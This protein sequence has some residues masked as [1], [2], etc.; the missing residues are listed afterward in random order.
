MSAVVDALRRNDPAAPWINIILR[1]ETSDA[2]LAQ[3]LEQNQ[4]VEQIDLDLR[5]VQTTNWEALL[6]VIATREKL[7]KVILFDSFDADNRNPAA[8][9]SAILRA[10]QQNAAIR[11]V[12]LVFLRLPTDLSLFLDTASSITSFSIVCDCDMTPDEREQGTRDL[13]VAIQRNTSIKTLHLGS[14]DD[15]Y[16]IPILQGLQ[17]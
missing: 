17:I 10:I 3:A 15:M 8:F 5:N 7:D 1:D 11:S 14:M 2:D 16:A 13:A 9:V 12:Q 6:H 4:F